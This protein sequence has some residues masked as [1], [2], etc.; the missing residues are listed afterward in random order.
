MMKWAADPKNR[1]NGSGVYKGAEFST[2]SSDTVRIKFVRG[3]PQ[4]LSILAL[5]P[6]VDLKAD[7]ATAPNGTGPY[8][9]ASFASGSD[10]KLLKNDNYWNKGNAP[11]LPAYEIRILPDN[12]GAMAALISHQIDGIAYPDFRQLS[13]LKSAGIEL[14]AQK[15][16]AQFVLRV[17][18]SK[19][20][21]ADKRVRE[22]LSFAIRR[23]VFAK[24]MVGGMGD[25]TCS[26]Y[27]KASVVYDPSIDANCKFDLDKAKQLFTEAGFG[28]GL[29]LSMLVSSVRQP[30]WA[31]YAP[32]FQEDLAKIG[33]K[34]KLEEV[35]PQVM[36]QHVSSGDYELQ[37]VWY[38][39]GS[40]DPAL[41]F[42]DEAFAPNVNTS[43]FRQP[44]YQQMVDDAQAEPDPKAR[45][46][47][48]RKLNEYMVDQA[49]MIPVSS[50]PYIYA[51]RPG[52]SGFSFDQFGMA[53]VNKTH[54]EN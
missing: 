1:V 40:F 19:G 15:P 34:L 3:T 14:I 17:N 20:P 46:E 52:V 7:L 23:D 12:A 29:T 32:L 27:P 43:W 22:A 24:K 37:G 18:A 28:S 45:L 42:V 49:F 38:G 6:I 16:S 35:A 44:A 53:N 39:W 54:I 25:P 26:P 41:F 13:Q 2:P 11:E 36:Q 47:K 9:V 48:Y 51:I 33:V 30:E 50:R 31:A 5:T 4:A 21:L 8:K 10:L